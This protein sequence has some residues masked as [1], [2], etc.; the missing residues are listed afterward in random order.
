MPFD[1]LPRIFCWNEDFEGPNNGL[2]CCFAMSAFYAKPQKHNHQ[3]PKI[4]VV[5]ACSRLAEPGP[6]GGLH[7]PYWRSVVTP[8]SFM[9]AG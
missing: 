4:L 8:V 5:V 2:S 3:D 1:E 7:S 9:P 6:Q